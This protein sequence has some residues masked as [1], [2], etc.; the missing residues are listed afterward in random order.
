MSILRKEKHFSDQIKKV[1]LDKELK[2]TKIVQKAV[3]VMKEDRQ[4]FGV[5]LGKEVNL[6]DAFRY[7]VTSVPL[8]LAFPHSTITQNPKHYFRNYLI[9]VTKACES[10]TQMKPAG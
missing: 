6:E 10:T 5:I 1:N 7:P 2:K 3:S 8:N 9:D 4:A